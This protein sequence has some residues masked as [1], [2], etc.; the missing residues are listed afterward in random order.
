M[1]KNQA[2]DGGRGLG[3]G[4]AAVAPDAQSVVGRPVL[5]HAQH[6]GEDAARERPDGG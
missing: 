5:A 3:G 1:I 4:P 6:L 2:E